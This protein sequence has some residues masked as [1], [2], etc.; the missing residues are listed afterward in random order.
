MI[1]AKLYTRRSWLVQYIDS[2]CNKVYRTSTSDS[3]HARPL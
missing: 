1:V 2:G 3:W